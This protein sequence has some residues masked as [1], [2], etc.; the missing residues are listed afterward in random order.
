MRGAICHRP[1]GSG[2][3]A[4]PRSRPTW[5][6]STPCAR[7]LEGEPLITVG[8]APHSVRA[9]P[10]D[11]LEAIAEA[12][13]RDGP[14]GAR[15]RRRAAP[16]DRRVAR[17]VRPAPDR[18]ARRLRAARPAHDDHPRDA[19]RRRRARPAGRARRDRVRLPEHRG[20]PRRRL[21]ARPSGCGP[22]ASRSRSGADSNTRLDPFEEARETEGLARRQAGRRNVLVRPGEDGPA[23]SLWECLTVNGARSLGPRAGRGRGRRAGR[24]R[25]ARPRSR[26]DLRRVTGAP[27]RPP[28]SSRAARRWCGRPGSRGRHS[29]RT[30]ESQ[31]PHMA[32]WSP[33]GMPPFRSLQ[34]ASSLP[35]SASPSVS[36]SLR[37]RRAARPDRGRTGGLRR[38]QQQLG[39]NDGYHSHDDRRCACGWSGGAG[40]AA[41]AKYTTCLKQ[42]GVTLPDAP[43]GRIRRRWRERRATDGATGATGPT[44][45]R[46]RLL[47]RGEQR[48]VPGGADRL[49]EAAARGLRPR[50]LLRRRR[51]GGRNNAAFAAY[52]NCLTLHGVKIGAGG[53]GRGGGQGGGR[54]ARPSRP[55]RSRRRSRRARACDPASGAALRRSTTTTPTTTTS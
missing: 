7:T 3:S 37:P 13:G 18:A 26:G 19:C 4:T 34:C 9:V 46:G 20:E 51:S 54:R 10:R 21:P 6:A 55:P 35:A 45:R 49:L 43:A 1:R 22:E 16:R 29:A 44:G 50:R 36:P 48:E 42:H 31:V 12:R 52:R 11:W 8:Y 38:R 24:S 25:R 23:R 30:L 5:P 41:F 53:F 27:R 14:P 39:R 17:R 28:C 47:L 32:G 40:R 15:A 2:A 33:E